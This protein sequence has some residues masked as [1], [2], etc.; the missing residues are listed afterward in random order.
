MFAR[1]ARE[2]T[3]SDTITYQGNTIDL[4]GSW[5]RI[6]LLDSLTEIGGIDK[7]LLGDR[8]G[9]LSYARANGIKITK[10]ERLGKVITKLFDVLGGAKTHPTDIYH[11]LSGGGIPAFPAE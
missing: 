4:G 8:E 7:E 3:G 10:Q 2:V 9:L 1:V 11:R 6:P 5:P